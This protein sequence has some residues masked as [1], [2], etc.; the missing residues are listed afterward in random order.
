MSMTFVSRPASG[1]SFAIGDRVVHA[2]KPEWGSGVV[3]SA[4]ATTH[5]GSPCQRLTIRFDRAGLK[6]I[7]TA[8]APIELAG[9]VAQ[10]LKPKDESHHDPLPIASAGHR[11]LLEIMTKIPD[12]ARDPFT[13]PAARL[14]ATLSLYRFESTG[15]SLIDW[16]AAQSGLP[17][18]LARFNRH[19]LE[20][21]YRMFANNLRSHLSK[22]V[23]EANN[24]PA[25]ELVRI[26]KSAPPAAQ[27][28][29]QK[30]HRPR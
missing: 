11:E 25:Q 18:P 6:T 14:E 9:E 17:D 1:S 16:A 3:S 19:E 29:L 4:S 2:S 21:Y 23:R 20:D 7:S 24:V 22:V 10:V 28:A 8:F 5:E 12:A 26:A 27:Q 13:S 15:G 30:L